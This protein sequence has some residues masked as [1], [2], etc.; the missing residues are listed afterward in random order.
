MAQ[1]RLILASNSPR[2][3]QMLAWSGWA[4]ELDPANLNEDPLPGEPPLSCHT[5]LQPLFWIQVPLLYRS[6]VH[7]RPVIGGE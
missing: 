6:F 3:R 5:L 1:P 7:P 4:F 2:R